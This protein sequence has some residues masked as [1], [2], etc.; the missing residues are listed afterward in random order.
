[1]LENIFAC[2][3]TL[4]QI[5]KQAA[6][7][8]AATAFAICHLPE[9]RGARLHCTVRIQQHFIFEGGGALAR[10]V[11]CKFPTPNL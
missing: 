9:V 2:M 10:R 6:V 5:D 11:G 7:S 1:M 3:Q 4:R 8:Q